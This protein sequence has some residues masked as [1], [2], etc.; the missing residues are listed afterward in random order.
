MTLLP[1]RNVLIFHLGALGDV[2]LTW[3]L[4]LALGR[5]YPQS[6]IFYVT[7]GQKGKLAERALRV[8]STDIEAGWH[9]LFSPDAVLPEPARKLMSSAHTVVSFLSDGR[10]VWAQNVSRLAPEAALLTLKPATLAAPPVDEHVTTFIHRQLHPWPAIATAFDQIHRSINDRGIGGSAKPDGSI[11]I[12]P[13][14]GA[15]SKCW[16]LE[17]FVDLAARLRQDGR[18]VRLVI[19]ETELDRWDRRSLDSLAGAERPA[20]LVAL[21]D[22]IRSAALF[23]GNDSGPAHLAGAL[24]VPTIVLYGPTSPLIWKPLGPK[25]TAVEAVGGLEGISVDRVIEAMR[26]NEQ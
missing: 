17:R 15:P 22:A 4:A 10:D 9:A 21:F 26:E 13:G 14:S 1:R 7:H 18:L 5:L 19:G 16:P 11:L 25:V 12:H 8:D 2:V 20:D 24:G 23:I 3:P 6:R